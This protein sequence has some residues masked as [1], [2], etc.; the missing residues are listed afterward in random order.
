VRLAIEPRA[1]GF[2]L[3]EEMNRFVIAA[4]CVLA[5]ASAAFAGERSED[6]NLT[7]TVLESRT[8][9]NGTTTTEVSTS[10]NTDNLGRTSCSSSGGDSVSHI[11]I[12]QIVEMSDGNTYVLQCAQGGVF[13]SFAAGVGQPAAASRGLPSAGCMISPG[14]YKARHDKNGFRFL[15]VDRRGKTPR[16]FFRILSVKQTAKPEVK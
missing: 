15:L 8:V 16:I 14:E 13:R 11:A 3:E 2:S 6:Y 5:C 4:C 9:N 10:C 12:Q 7:A 1:A